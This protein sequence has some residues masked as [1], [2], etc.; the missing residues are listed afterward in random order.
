MLI[1]YII[2]SKKVLIKTLE[3]ALMVAMAVLVVDVLYGVGTRY[4]LGEQA[5]WTEELARMLLIWVS[6]LGGAVA[7]GAKAHLGVDYLV[8]KMEV[9]SQKAM[10]LIVDLLVLFFAVS[11]LLVGGWSLTSETFHFGQMMM[12]LDIPKGYV[13]MAVPIS[14]I[15]FIIFA[16]ESMFETFSGVKEK[17]VESELATEEVQTT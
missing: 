13:Y 4:L 7:Y 11:V 15:F 8:E 9:V 1:S 16:L 5:S 17:D 2:K 12:A 14:G 3:I 6:L 10:K